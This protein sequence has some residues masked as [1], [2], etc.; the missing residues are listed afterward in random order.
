MGTCPNTDCP[1]HDVPINLGPW[2]V[3]AVACGTCGTQ[4]AAIGPSAAAER[5][6]D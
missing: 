6:A 1:Q 5:P 4:L 3:D 2:P